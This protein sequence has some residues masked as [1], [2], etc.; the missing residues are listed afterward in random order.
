MRTQL[1]QRLHPGAQ[2]RPWPLLP[3]CLYVPPHQHADANPCPRTRRYSHA[4][5][6]TQA[7]Q[8]ARRASADSR[9]NFGSGSPARRLERAKQSKKAFIKQWVRSVWAA[10]EGEVASTEGDSDEAQGKLGG[11]GT[12]NGS[13]DSREDEIVILGQ[14][15]AASIRTPMTGMTAKSKLTIKSRNC[16]RHLNLRE[17]GYS[18]AD[19][20]MFLVS[21]LVLLQPHAHWQQRDI[22]VGPLEPIE[23]DLN[24]SS[25][26]CS[27]TE[28]ASRPPADVI[29]ISGSDGQEV[30]DEVMKVNEPGGWEDEVD[31]IEP[32]Q[33]KHPGTIERT[34][35]AA[36]R[37]AFVYA[38]LR[39]TGMK[40]LRALS[41]FCWN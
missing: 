35:P 27:G 1:L 4:H 24:T 19:E 41:I 6:Y 3:P 32:P 28:N 25:G 8:A 9:R 21:F 40:V 38:R 31:E 5:H 18:A 33:Q 23:I 12:G 7:R 26:S 36:R 37:R 13:W 2:V 29:M 14:R 20:K 11:N 16:V 15:Y 39:S 22:H 34:Q 30:R 10:T 17:L